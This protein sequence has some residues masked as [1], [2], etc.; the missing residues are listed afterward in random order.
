MK[1]GLGK[2]EMEREEFV[3]WEEECLKLELELV[4]KTV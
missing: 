2:N 1:R 4:K 3:K